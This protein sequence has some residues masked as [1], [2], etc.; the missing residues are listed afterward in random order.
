MTEALHGPTCHRPVNGD[1]AMGIKLF[2][3][4]LALA[5]RMRCLIRLCLG[6]DGW[7]PM[8]TLPSRWPP[9]WLEDRRRDLLQAHRRHTRRRV[10]R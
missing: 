3:S 10:G 6:I 7:R 5:T 8:P 2:G 9:R 4:P 1:L